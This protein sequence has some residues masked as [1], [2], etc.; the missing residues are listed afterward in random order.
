[1][2]GMPWLEEHGFP[3]LHDSIWNLQHAESPL[4]VLR[5]ISG[6]QGFGQVITTAAA[7]DAREH[8][9]TW[10]EIADALRLS[11][12]AVHR[13]YAQGEPGEEE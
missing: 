8:G 5:A 13:R 7:Q 6:L 9:V 12:Q 1:M 4:T 3:E 10:Q 2:G 11:R